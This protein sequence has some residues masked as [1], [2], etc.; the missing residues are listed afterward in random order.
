[1]LTKATKLC[2]VIEPEPDAEGKCTMLTVLDCFIIMVRFHLL[3][4]FTIYFRDSKTQNIKAQKQ[5]NIGKD[6]WL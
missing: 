4:F 6:L 3:E 2:H 5:D 1:M